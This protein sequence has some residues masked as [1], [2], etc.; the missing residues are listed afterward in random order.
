MTAKIPISR[1]RVALVDDDDY[2]WLSEHRW[3]AFSGFGHEYAGRFDGPNHHRH[4]NRPLLLM[5]RV[6]AGAGPEML[7]DHINHDGLDNRRSN[8]RICTKS[9][10]CIHRAG[11]SRSKS[12]YWGVRFRRRAWDGYIRVNGKF[13]CLGQF[14]TAEDAARAVDAA[15]RE[16]HG[17]FAKQNFP[18]ESDQ[19]KEQ[20]DE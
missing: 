20:W 17:E 19:G 11:K 14:Q 10:N 1:G 5:H 18:T 2:E 16:Y 15:A 4:T 9:Q 8:L 12:G 3:Y 13:L 6:I 7:V